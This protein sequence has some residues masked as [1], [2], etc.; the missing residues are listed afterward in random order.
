MQ[1]SCVP[2]CSF[3]VTIGFSRLCRYICGKAML[4][5]QFNQIFAAMPPVY[6]RRHS[7]KNV[8]A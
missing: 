8:K 6:E 5:R 4:F 1:Q 2:H 7:R 3:R